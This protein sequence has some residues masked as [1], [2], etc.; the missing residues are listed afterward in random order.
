MLEGDYSYFLEE[1]RGL[2]TK[3]DEILDKF[4][5]IFNEYSSRIGEYDK[6]LDKVSNEMGELK[7][8]LINKVDVLKIYFMMGLIN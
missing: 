4:D 2:D 7:N 8:E 5:V 6:I 1:S 3:F